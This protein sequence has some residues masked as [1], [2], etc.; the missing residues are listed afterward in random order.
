MVLLICTVC[1]ITVGVSLLYSG[2]CDYVCPW[3]ICTGVS[4][5][6][7]YASFCSSMRSTMPCFPGTTLSSLIATSYFRLDSCFDLC[8][9]SPKALHNSCILIGIHQ[10]YETCFPPIHI[11][12]ALLKNPNVVLILP[13][14]SLAHPVNILG[15]QTLLMLWF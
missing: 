11:L 13:L 4:S 3:F 10:P 2:C 12:N 8:Y 1:T 5:A 9:L 7:I 14:V 6:F 15:V